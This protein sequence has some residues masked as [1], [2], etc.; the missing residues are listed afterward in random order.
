VN[1]AKTVENIAQVL[2]IITFVVMCW[3]AHRT[4]QFRTQCVSSSYIS[5]VQIGDDRFENCSY[6]SRLSLTGLT[7]R[8]SPERLNQLRALEVLEP[9][10]GV[11]PTRA[12]HLAVEIN[13]ENPH[14][15]ELGRGYLRLGEEW[16]R[17]GRQTERALIMALLKG[18]QPQNYSGEFQLEVMAD[19]L[20]MSVLNEATELSH[21]M[22]EEVKFPTT[23]PSFKDYCKSP[24]RS[25]AHYKACASEESSSKV[26]GFRPLMAVALWRMFEKASLTQK[27]RTL[28]VIR[29]GDILPQF[30]ELRDDSVA[31]MVAWFQASLQEQLG[32]L[33]F[34]DDDHEQWAF[35]RTMKELEVEAPTHWELTVDITNTPAWRDIVEQFRTWSRFHHNERTLIFTPEGA[36]AFPSGLP[37]AW[38][39]ADIQSQKHVMIACTWPKPEEVV[40]VSARH[41]YAQHSCGKID[42]VFW[43]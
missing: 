24:F 28:Q 29:L 26:W 15:F 16:L 41:T 20:M 12:P 25:L 7:R 32:G 21:S 37:V 42:E 1:S 36:L 27:M 39:K 13:L 23:A 4:L 35:K 6:E 11:I 9:L 8:V 2:S 17:D 14:Q 30:P 33:K 22:T 34:R 10:K 40:L 19:F 18:G 5:F 3:V 38:G 31:G 43:N